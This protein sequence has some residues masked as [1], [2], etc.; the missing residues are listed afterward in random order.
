MSPIYRM[1]VEQLFWRLF[2]AA[3]C[4]IMGLFTPEKKLC[5]FITNASLLTE[6][7]LKVEM[8]HQ[9]CSNTSIE[10]GIVAMHWGFAG[11][12][13]CGNVMLRCWSI[14]ATWF[15]G[16]S[17]QSFPLA[18]RCS[19]PFV[20]VGRG[21]YA[22]W[23]TGTLCGCQRS[24]LAYL[25]CG[26][27]LNYVHFIHC[28]FT[29]PIIIRLWRSVMDSIRFSLLSVCVPSFGRSNGDAAAPHQGR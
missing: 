27:V 8:Q 15:G 12:P 9:R 17:C 25:F 13:Y 3:L 10:I 6:T 20:F 7:Q 26:S 24:C 14:V 11:M 29:L 23:D 22:G 1:Q 21:W 16:R 19:E 18:P 28:T 2:T 5:R 4:W